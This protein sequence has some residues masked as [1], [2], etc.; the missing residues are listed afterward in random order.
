MFRIGPTFQLRWSVSGVP[1]SDTRISITIQKRR[2]GRDR[3]HTLESNMDTNGYQHVYWNPTW[4][5][6]VNIHTSYWFLVAAFIDENGLVMCGGST[7]RGVC[8]LTT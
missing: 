8:W 1:S 4:I 3:A 2:P 7:W 5:H 6:M